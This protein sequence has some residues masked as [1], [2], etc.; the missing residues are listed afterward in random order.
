ML[1]LLHLGA[2]RPKI[3]SLGSDTRRV[4]ITLGGEQITVRTVRV[5]GQWRI[6]L[7]ED[8]DAALEES[9]SGL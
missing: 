7:V 9:D 6:E 2:S 1:Q 8:V 3:V 5:A 4:S